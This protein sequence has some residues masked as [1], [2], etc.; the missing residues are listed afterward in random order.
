MAEWQCF[1]WRKHN[2]F[3]IFD[4]KCLFL[5]LFLILIEK[6]LVEGYNVGTKVSLMYIAEW[7]QDLHKRGAGT[8]RRGN[9]GICDWQNSG[10]S[11]IDA[12]SGK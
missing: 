11:G 2:N 3:L 12:H 5:L 9:V 10:V 4:I 7:K 6:K 1:F 8:N